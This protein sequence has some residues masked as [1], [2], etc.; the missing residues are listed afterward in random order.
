MFNLFKSD[1]VKKLEK[2]YGK[3]LEEA[4]N[5]QRNGKMDVYAKISADA[6]KIGKQIDELKKNQKDK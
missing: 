2:E 3:M 4:M 1:P 6:E 5:A